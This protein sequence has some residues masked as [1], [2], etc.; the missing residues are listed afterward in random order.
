MGILRPA[1]LI[2]FCVGVVASIAAAR[3]GSC[4]DNLP[5]RVVMQSEAPPKVLADVKE[6]A[7]YASRTAPVV[8]S[9]AAYNSAC[10]PIIVREFDRL[11]NSGAFLFVSLPVFGPSVIVEVQSDHC[12]SGAGLQPVIFTV[13]SGHLV[14]IPAPMLEHGNMDGYAIGGLAHDQ[15]GI[16]T[17][18]AIWDQGEAHYS[19][20]SYEISLYS[21][22]GTEFR[23]VGT[24]TTANKYDP[25][26]DAAATS[27]LSDPAI[28]LP[29]GFARPVAIN[30]DAR[31]R[32]RSTGLEPDCQ[33]YVVR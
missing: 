29:M 28:R 20:H 30:W 7:L 33:S 18:T 24:Q 32:L 1:F 9:A 13:R 5:Q 2:L 15:L 19:P 22:A 23:Q 10:A 6:V 16:L 8:I 3:A 26:G 31:F 25:F 11:Y 14:E 12:G 17:W 27:P 21:W 4:V